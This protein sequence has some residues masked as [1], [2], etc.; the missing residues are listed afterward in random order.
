MSRGY[1][2]I[3]CAYD[4]FN[5]EVDYAAWADFAE[6]CFDTY[7]PARPSLVLDLACGTG[8]LTELLSE[9]GYDM[10]GVDASPEML[11]VARE[12]CSENTLLLCQNM[13]AF[14]LYGTVGATIC[15]LDSL[16]HLTRKGELE[17]CFSL[18][19]NY[20]D[21]DGIFLFDVNSA[22]RF[23]MEYARESYQFE[24]ELDD[25][26]AVFCNWQNDYSEKRGICRF[27][28]TLFT[29]SEAGSGI[30]SRSDEEWSE[31]YYSREELTA[32]LEGAGFELLGVFGS[33]NMRPPRKNDSKLY[34][35]A[36][37][38]K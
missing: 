32:A 11:S 33:T 16:N 35:A 24:D 38:K 22:Y 13:C 10:T 28:I 37:A 20:L 7:L 8:T 3:S 31:R 34:F 4:S 25:G 18:V 1:G 23:S 29:E 19:H 2:A 5:G 6:R 21:P 12:R 9:R 30:Y 26:R 17:K 14:E 15:S 36:R 27:Y